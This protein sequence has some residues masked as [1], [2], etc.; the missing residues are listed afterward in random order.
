MNRQNPPLLIESYYIEYGGATNDIAILLRLVSSDIPNELIENI[1]AFF[2]TN[3]KSYCGE[4]R[5]AKSSLSNESSYGTVINVNPKF[6][7]AT[8]VP[9]NQF[10][11]YSGLK[12]QIAGTSYTAS[13]GL[14]KVNF[15]EYLLNREPEDIDTLLVHMRS[16]TSM[17]LV[18]HYD[19][20]KKFMILKNIA[21]IK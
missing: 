15:G 16:A 17:D 2:F 11:M 4:L 8:V 6:V 14:R 7:T 3:E 10:D 5:H 21:I 18:L 20:G 9:I 19:H 13:E 1:K 12:I